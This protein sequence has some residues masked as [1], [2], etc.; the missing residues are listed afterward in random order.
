MEEQLA[1]GMIPDIRR[2]VKRKKVVAF[3]DDP[4]I[5]RIMRG[6]VNF[7]YSEGL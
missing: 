1:I 3:Y 6:D 7:Y 5:E 2:A 4:E